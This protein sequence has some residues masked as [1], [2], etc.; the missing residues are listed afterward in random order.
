[1]SGPLDKYHPF[2]D[3]LA[4]A[5]GANNSYSEESG[6]S[7]S[8][9]NSKHNSDDDYDGGDYEDSSAFGGFFR[10]LP[11]K[12]KLALIALVAGGAMYAYSL[13]GEV[14]GPSNRS[15]SRDSGYSANEYDEENDWSYRG[16]ASSKRSRGLISGIFCG[17][18]Q[19][20]A[21]CD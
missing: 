8:S 21:F 11:L 3:T 20:P 14:L 7:S 18:H 9:G 15:S 17:G 1:M 2:R 13:L 19:R 16:G 5:G 4:G 12:G 6:S 10:R